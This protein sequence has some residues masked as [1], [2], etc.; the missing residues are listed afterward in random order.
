MKK[1]IG[2]VSPV[3]IQYECWKC[4]KWHETNELLAAAQFAKVRITTRFGVINLPDVTYLMQLRSLSDF[5]W[6][7]FIDQYASRCTGCNRY[8]LKKN[9][10]FKGRGEIHCYGC[11]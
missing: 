3:T 1:T 11:M 9:L 8:K 5:S 10:W 2:G 4:D 7:A 6:S